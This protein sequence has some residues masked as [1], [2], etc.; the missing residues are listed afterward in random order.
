MCWSDWVTKWFWWWMSCDGEGSDLEIGWSSFMNWVT[1]WSWLGRGHDGEGSP[2]VRGRQVWL[3]TWISGDWGTFTIE[4]VRITCIQASW[5]EY[6]NGPAYGWMMIAK[7]QHWRDEV[8]TS[9]WGKV[10][11]FW[12]HFSTSVWG[13]GQDLQDELSTLVWRKVHDTTA[14]LSL[15]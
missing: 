8:S 3:S 2:W 7:V 1:K 15:W 12:N 5:I 14:T 11:H 10:Q 4:K 13:K 6:L 9:V